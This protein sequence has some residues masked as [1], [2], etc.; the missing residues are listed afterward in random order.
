MLLSW[1]AMAQFNPYLR[2]RSVQYSPIV[3]ATDTAAVSGNNGKTW[4]DFTTH[5]FRGIRNATKFS[6]GSGGGSYTFGSGLTNSSGNVRFGGPLTQS[7]TVTGLYSTSFGSS[8]NNGITVFNINARDQLNL[9]SYGSQ[10]ATFNTENSIL[11]GTNYIEFRSYLNNTRGVHMSLGVSGTSDQYSGFRLGIDSSDESAFDASNTVFQIF[12]SGV[13][14]INLGSDAT[15]DLYYRNSSGNFSRLGIGSAGK[16]LT[17]GAGTPYWEDPASAFSDALFKLWD[18]GDATKQLYFDASNI[19][20]S[21][22]R[23][24]SAPDA[25]GTIALTNSTWNRT[26]TSALSGAVNI[27]GDGGLLSIYSASG[28]DYGQTSLS[29]TSASLGFV[30]SGFGKG[31]QMTQGSIGVGIYDAIGSRG[32]YYLDDYSSAGI[33]THGNRWIPDKEYVDNA[34]ISAKLIAPIELSGTSLT[35]TNAHIGQVIITTNGSATTI[36][37]PSGLTYGFNCIIIQKGAGIVSL[38]VSAVTLIGK[39]ATT[40]ANDTLGILPD[41]TADNYIGK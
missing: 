28:G 3:T 18:N 19:T 5:Q 27:A 8:Y 13:W 37:V 39:S 21:T 10:T 32:A 6:F 29:G 17:V 1:S 40:G 16:V 20:T 34:L 11:T 26:G 25:S 4:Y 15:G 35:L 9:R 12:N 41:L 22:T 2:A 33:S 7:A 30:D 23:T 36:T 31:I 14:K 24:L 38:N